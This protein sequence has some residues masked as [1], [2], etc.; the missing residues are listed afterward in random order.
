LGSVSQDATAGTSSDAGADEPPIRFRGDEPELYLEFNH[1][2]VKKLYMHVNAS[3]E[4]IEDAAAFAW[5]QFFRYQ[6]DR[7]Q[8]WKGWLYR[9]AQREAWRLNAAQSR[10]ELHI[11]TD[12]HAGKPGLTPEPPDPRDRL[13]ER[14]EFL[15]ALEE[16]RHLPYNLR[17]VVLL[18]SQVTRHR[19]VAEV[20]GITTGR[21]AQLMQDVGVRLQQRAELRVELERPFANPRAA[22]LRELETDAPKWLIEAIGRA[23]TVGKSSSKVVLTWRRAALAIEDY[24][25]EH[26]WNH[27]EIGIGPTPI[28][29]AARDAHRHVERTIAQ[30]HQERVLRKGGPE[31]ER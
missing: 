25:T 12:S 31:L 16:L 10:A 6:P 24:R 4:D 17:R 7:D 28:Q 19:E 8:A 5:L 21:V 13:D 11:V 2:L 22:R 23:P 15:A 30:V 29:P 27:E 1:E 20:L 9:T 18:R 26:G 14:L 3:P